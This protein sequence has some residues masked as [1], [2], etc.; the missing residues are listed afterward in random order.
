MFFPPSATPLQDD[1]IKGVS[2]ELIQRMG[3]NAC[4]LN[5][6]GAR[7][8]EPHGA[9]H[10]IVYVL[11]E[12]PGAQEIKEGIP[13]VGQAGQVLRW[14]IPEG[15]EGKIRWNNVVRSRTDEDNRDP[16]I[17]EMEACRPSVAGDI[18][19]SRPKV[20][21]GTGNIP[22]WWAL[23]ETGIT[24]WRG[25]RIPVIIGGHACWYFPVM[26][27]SYISRIRKTN[28]RTLTEY[29]SEEEFAFAM[30]LK[31]AFALA[32]VLLS[33]IVHDEAHVKANIEI[34]TGSGH[35]DLCRVTTFLNSCYNK[36]TVGIDYET[37]TD[38]HSPRPYAAGARI[39]SVALA[40]QGGSLAFP[41]D[42]PKA[43]WRKKER[44]TLNQ[45]LR[46]FL[47]KA[48]C[49]K[50]AH[51]LSFEL[52]WTGFF[53]GKETLRAQPW[54]DTL[55]MAYVLDQ[56]RGTLSL[57]FQ[58][59]EHFGINIKD[60]SQID[61]RKGLLE[62]PLEK[63]LTYNAID[64][65]YH[66][67][68]YLKL[69]QRLKEARMLEVYR[70][71]LERVPTAVLTQMKGI[72]VDQSRV[73][74]FYHEL[75]AAE[76]LVHKKIFA[77]AEAKEY[78]RLT[79]KQFNPSS[80]PNVKYVLSKIMGYKDIES[81]TDQVLSKYKNP[82]V[83][84]ISD[85][86][87]VTK[88][89]STYVLPLLSRQELSRH[90]RDPKV[91]CIYPDGLI[92]HALR[93]TSTDTSRTSSDAPNIQNQPKHDEATIGNKQIK[94][95]DFRSQIRP[96]KATER[97][98]SFDFGQIQARNVAMESRDPNLVK[99][100][101]DRHDIHGDWAE[102]MVKKHPSWV[103]E[104]MKAYNSDKA[105]RAHYRQR[106][107]NEFVFATFFGA[108]AYS[109]SQRLGIPENLVQ[110]LLDEFWEE[111]PG[112]RAWQERIKADYRKT[113]YVTGLSGFRRHAPVSETQ[114]INSSIQADEAAIVLDAM[115]RL[116]KLDHEKLQAN[117]EIHDSLDFFWE[118]DE[119]EKLSEIVISEMLKTSFEWAEIVPLVVERSIGEDW[120]NMVEDPEKYASDTW[121]K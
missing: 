46:D 107:K 83:K 120:S 22:L 114:Q 24:K 23:K 64:A 82:F 35:D 3:C 71:Q 97:I 29:G 55:S 60:L 58:C 40:H 121:Q 14:R 91:S 101:W 76:D 73:S 75:A 44:A 61:T 5:R 10:P 81:T 118:K 37:E 78:C 56:R 57:E 98:V 94:L 51:N 6:P 66:R 34:V 62:V 20:V 100:M 99:S 106:S 110:E 70:N 103:E 72:P 16:A 28:P 52:E 67:L 48:P 17:E 84:L 25:R 21:I 85:W 59:L 45:A 8:L 93:T 116:S 104:G 1:R 96:L 30:D 111:F 32:E 112:V 117:M 38:E 42:H 15:W 68:L 9:E 90:G 12:A 31:R 33:P 74:A 4:P 19:K 89:S 7:H 53:Y 105:I 115:T 50:I 49:K 63:L 79:Q 108:Q 36:K 69:H 88:M 92:H 41:L 95:K 2:I 43:V 109:S 54:E 26:H 47:A 119:I 27:P 65:K 87:S 18:A 113:G 86:R 13:F 39:L 11:G 77:S 102:R 80:V